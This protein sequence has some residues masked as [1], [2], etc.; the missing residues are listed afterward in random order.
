M[1]NIKVSKRELEIIIA[2]ILSFVPVGLMNNRV[3]SFVWYG[4]ISLTF[5]SFAL[6]IFRQ[7]EKV[8]KG[9]FIMLFL[10]QFVFI[11]TI[12]PFFDTI[13]ISI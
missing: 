13:K 8:K 11:Q 1:S 7:K 6:K 2:L 4:L 3:T 12:Q 10:Y 5:V 9:I